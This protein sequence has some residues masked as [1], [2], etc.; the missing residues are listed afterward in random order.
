MAIPIN[1][2]DLINC[3]VIESNRVKSY[4]AGTLLQ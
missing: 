4:L 3:R 1:I 2:N